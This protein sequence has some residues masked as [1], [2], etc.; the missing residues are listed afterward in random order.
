MRWSKIKNIIILL[1]VVVN[2]FL[3]AQV[4]WRN[5]QGARLEQEARQRMIAVLE[6]S[7]LTFL[8]QEVPGAMELPTVRLT[9]SPPAQA[10]AEAL[11]G[12]VTGVSTQ[13]AR[14]TYTG[15]KGSVM[16]SA[17]GEMD[18]TFTP[19]A[20][21]APADLPALLASLGVETGDVT[22]QS[23]DGVQV[24]RYTQLFHGAPIPG[25]TAAVYQRD[26]YLER[27]TLRR[28]VGETAAPAA[29][30]DALSASTALARFL[31]E[32]NRG[33]GY[34]CSQVTELYSGYT[35]SGA[36]V[37]TLSPAWFV[38]TDTWHFSVDANTGSVSA[39]E[40]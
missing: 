27:I 32:L 7:E 3:L 4:G 23:S 26:G 15:E 20:V 6:R 35:L 38:G 9:V 36:G 18:A 40:G 28:L 34:V 25:L 1:L 33:E 10:E 2:V 17:T 16:C 24:S 31:D 19:G 8:P 13:G 11:V 12:S 22:Q 21:E 14:T 39:T 30:G 29:A 37:V 5:Y